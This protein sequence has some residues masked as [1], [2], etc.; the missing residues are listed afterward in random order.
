[1]NALCLD[2]PEWA[3]AHVSFGELVATQ[4]VEFEATIR[5]AVT[6]PTREYAA[7]LIGLGAVVRRFALTTT[8]S[9]EGADLRVGTRA[10]YQRGDY[11]YDCRVLNDPRNDP[12]GL[13]RVQILSH[14]SKRSP[15]AQGSRVTLPRELHRLVELVLPNG[16]T[17]SSVLGIGA[18]K[19]AV[20]GSRTASYVCCSSL[21]AI[22]CGMKGRLLLEAEIELMDDSMVTARAIDVLRPQAIDSRCYRSDIVSQRASAE[23][24]EQPNESPPIVVFDGAAAFLGCRN[25]WPTASWIVAIDRTDNLD[26]NEQAIATLDNVFQQAVELT[27]QPSAE[28]AE[29]RACALEAQQ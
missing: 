7:V 6:V 22:L 9:E 27:G 3:Q 19:M 20:G 23:S 17:L 10:R 18:I 16:Q 29:Y 11:A 28:G 8:P 12:D 25:R 14:E 13:L 15:L 5:A 24:T 4:S 1:V 2:L 21:E 26:L